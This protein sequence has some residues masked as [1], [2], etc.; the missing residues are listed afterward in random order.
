MSV[1]LRFLVAAVVLCLCLGACSEHS[2]NSIENESASPSNIAEADTS[3]KTEELSGDE[4][5]YE[6]L[7]KLFCD[8]LFEINS[9]AT[10]DP[11]DYIKHM[12]GDIEI[13]AEDCITVNQLPYAR[14]SLNYNRLA[15]YYANFFTDEAL[16]WI[17]STKF[18]N[19]EDTVYCC[20]VG[21]KTGG[22]IQLLSISKLQKNTY[23]A[24]FLYN[25]GVNQSEE[26]SSVFEIKETDAGYRISS[27][28]YHPASLD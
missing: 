22:N 3:S 23:N 5:T 21:G 10:E 11:C 12:F 9:L 28:D 4:P 2:S 25:Y 6:Q 13:Y 19:I 20:M 16:E 24:A 17:L 8:A 18:V 1:K 27:M 14:T 7:E 15:E 26:K